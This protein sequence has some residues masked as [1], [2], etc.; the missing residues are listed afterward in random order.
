RLRERLSPRAPARRGAHRAIRSDHAFGTDRWSCARRGRR[1]S[2]RLIAVCGPRVAI[3]AEYVEYARS[4]AGYGLDRRLLVREERLAAT[5]NCGCLR[6]EH[7]RAA[8][9]R[10]APGA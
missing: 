2:L 6:D 1:A 10:R 7:G 4:F 9:G 5:R 8:A 3:S